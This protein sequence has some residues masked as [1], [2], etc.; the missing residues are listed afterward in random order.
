MCKMNFE[1]LYFCV[2]EQALLDV[3]EEYGEVRQD[4]ID[5]LFSP[6]T[7]PL[8]FRSM[9]AFLGHDEQI[10]LRRVCDYLYSRK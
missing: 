1:R 6:S 4:A 5:W 10:Y 9:C 7:G 2:I 8:S 3:R